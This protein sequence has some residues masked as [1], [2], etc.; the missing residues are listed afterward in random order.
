MNPLG[1]WTMK[2]QTAI[3]SVNLE[4]YFQVAPMRRI[5]P[6]RFWPRFDLRIER[7]TLQALDL[8]D[9]NDA[10]ATFFVSGWVA[11]RRPD[12][13]AE[14]ARRGHDVASKGY[15][16]RP[17]A[18]M[19][20][21]EFR[22]DL[23]R[24]RDAI[25][26]AT[27]ETVRGYRIAEGSLPGDGRAHLEIL[28]RAGLHF[29]AS[30]RP[31][32]PRFAGRTE[33][34][35]IHRVEGAGWAITEVPLS[36]GSLLGIPYP[37]TGGNYMRQMPR[38][39]FESRVAALQARGAFW[40]FYFHVWELDPEQPR[41]SAV[42]G[43]QRM[44][45]YRNLDR[46]RERVERT[47]EGSRFTSISDHLGLPVTTAVP[48][49]VRP[50]E[51]VPVVTTERARDVTIV[52]PCYNEEDT[53]PY[54]AGNLASLE[55]S[56]AASYRFSYVFV[57]DGSKDATWTVL[58]RL[59]GDRPNCQLVK[60]PQNRGI[61][62]ATMT[63]I[64]H[65]RDEIVCGIDCDCSFDPHDLPRMIPLLKPGI[66]MV[67]ASPYHRDGGVMN[68]PAWRL[69]LSRGCCNI[70]RRILTHKFSSYT[71]CFRVY[72]RS[73]IAHVTLEDGGF[74]GIMEMF[75]KLD[76]NGSRIVEFPAVLATR[77]LGV[78]K[79]KTLRVIRSHLRLMAR[80]ALTPAIEPTPPGPASGH[81]MGAGR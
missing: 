64:A 11:D 62:A 46:M 33:T 68:V 69:M 2:N 63:G 14:V 16:H 30:L 18:Q 27:G 21:D 74:L 76:R 1:G 15:L 54:L 10:R 75:V 65:A 71:A 36:S 53:L 42:T 28:A 78:S 38:A 41:V 9:R 31:F 44:R 56:E 77:L 49:P 52:V 47:L 35:G 57:D 7:S 4:D 19:S 26:R 81:H 25:E 24:S 29:D 80:T 13:V 61:A 17:A 79:M 45:Q 43:L 66:D 55:A 72:R 73:A 60:H 6:N 48:A 67:Q 12:L 39:L 23:L 59:F 50:V 34:R 37:V 3:L 5:I 8:L 22:S 70:Y 20:L 51:S 32:G 58:Q 40:H